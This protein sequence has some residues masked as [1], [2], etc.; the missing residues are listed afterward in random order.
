MSN[1][2]AAFN[3]DMPAAVRQIVER[4][5]AEIKEAHNRIHDLQRAAGAGA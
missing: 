1:Y 2:C 4:Q 5:F 3:V